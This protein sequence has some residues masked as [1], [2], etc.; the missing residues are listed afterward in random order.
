[1]NTAFWCV[2]VAGLLPYVATI[3][4][5]AGAR[6]DNAQPRSWLNARTGWRA[7]ANAAQL[8]GFEAFPLF[9]AAVIIASIRHA[10]EL[11]VDQ[12]AVAFVALRVGYFAAY[13][14]NLAWLRSVL[15]LGGI[16]CAVAI[17]VSGT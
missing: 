10:P 4:A 16:A 1:M 14:A 2:L 6:F 7:R 15:W 8:N 3:S 13:L 11:R 12:L 9:A 17:F 5:K